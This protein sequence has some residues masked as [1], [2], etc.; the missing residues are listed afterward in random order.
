MKNTSPFQ[1]SRKFHNKYLIG[2]MG[3]RHWHGDA[4]YDDWLSGGLRK[5]RD[6]STSLVD[7]RGWENV[8]SR[9]LWSVD[10]RE[11]Q[12]DALLRPED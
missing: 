9:T 5:Q 10:R 7:S 3:T 4:R 12:Q 8:N 2:I 6:F 11:V 1:A